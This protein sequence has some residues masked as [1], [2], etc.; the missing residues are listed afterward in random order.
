MPIGVLIYGLKHDC[1]Y[2]IRVAVSQKSA[3][4]LYLFETA[5]A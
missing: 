4:S 3:V 1:K 5:L 2:I